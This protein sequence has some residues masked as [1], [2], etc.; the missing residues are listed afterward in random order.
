MTELM[1]YCVFKD[2]NTCIRIERIGAFLLFWCPFV[3]NY[4]FAFL[5]ESGDNRCSCWKKQLVGNTLLEKTRYQKVSTSEEHVTIFFTSVLTSIGSW[6]YLPMYAA[7]FVCFS[8][9]LF[10]QIQVCE[11]NLL[12]TEKHSTHSLYSFLF[13]KKKKGKKNAYT[14]TMQISMHIRVLLLSVRENASLKNF[15]VTVTSVVELKS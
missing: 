11:T 4:S 12:G 6:T 3:R 14:C 2:N 13:P 10:F 15:S 7:I 9:I 1:K 8:K 5:K